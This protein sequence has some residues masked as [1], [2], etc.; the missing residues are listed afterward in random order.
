MKNPGFHLLCLS[1]LL[2]CHSKSDQIMDAFKKVDASINRSKDSLLMDNTACAYYYF[3][4]QQAA[5][6]NKA[7]SSNAD[8]LYTSIKTATT[9]IDEI[10]NRLQAQDSAGENTHV[11]TAFL[12][13]TPTGDRLERSIMDV[14]NHCYSGLVSPGKKAVLDSIFSS[15]SAFPHGRWQET[16]FKNVP[17]VAALTELDYCRNCCLAGARVT[18]VD[19]DSALSRGAN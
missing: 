16:Y 12:L 3:R 14:Y 9:L 1:L 8:T 18:L 11:A 10:H 4:I 2:G 13:H 15:F 5:A 7:L 6:Q 19:M 17:T